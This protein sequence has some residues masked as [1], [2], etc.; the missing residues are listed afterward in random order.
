MADDHRHSALSTDRGHMDSE[1]EKKEIGIK[2]KPG[3]STG[4]PRR[5]WREGSSPALPLSQPSA[6]PILLP[7]SAPA[8]PG[9]TFSG[10]H[11]ASLSPP[12][13]LIVAV[14]SCEHPL[15]VHQDAPTL[16]FGV[17][18]YGCHPGLRILPTVKSSDDPRLDGRRSTCGRGVG[19]GLAQRGRWR[20]GDSRIQWLLVQ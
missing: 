14:G 2:C 1:T 19:V 11:P 8:W 15:G 5:P 20:Q 4:R 17:V 12:C 3:G 16:E 18:V 13:S 7:F 6:G 9:V 10:C